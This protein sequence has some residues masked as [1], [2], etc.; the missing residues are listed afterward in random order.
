MPSPFGTT[1]SSGTTTKWSASPAGT[2]GGSRR[3]S[4]SPFVIAFTLNA[5]TL[6][7]A[8]RLWVEPSVR[9]AFVN[10]ARNATTS[11]SRK[12]H[13]TDE[14][15]SLPVLLGW[16]LASARHDPQG[17]PFYEKWSAFWA[18]LAKVIGLLLTVVAISFGAPFWFDA[19]SKLAR[20]RNSGMPP[21]SSDAASSAGD[22]T[23]SAKAR[24]IV[25]VLRTRTAR[26]C[27][28]AAP[29]A[30]TPAMPGRP[31]NTALTAVPGPRNSLHTRNGDGRRLFRVS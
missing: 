12:T 28:V 10:E 2:D 19:L 15:A 6:Q 5:D 24:T 21:P 26:Q 20:L 29:I 3:S 25:G 13:L 23:P 1:S 8:K 9:A 16:H 30:A 27:S 14:L 31:G 17:F 22:A 11:G 7:I 18:L 4:G